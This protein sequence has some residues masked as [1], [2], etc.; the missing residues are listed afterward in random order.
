M[1]DTALINQVIQLCHRAGEA[2]LDVYNHSA[3]FDIDTKADDSP[4]TEADLA[5][6]RI[7]ESGLSEL[8]AGVPVLSEESSLPPFAERS[9][10]Q[11]YWIVDPLDGTKEFINRNGEFTVNVALIEAGRPVLGVVYVPTTGVTYGGADGPGAFKEVD[12]NRQAIAVRSIEA[13]RS[14]GLPV[15]VVA[16]RRHGAS[17]VDQLLDKIAAAFGPV[18]TTSMGSSLKLCLVAEGAADIYPRLAL[19][20]EWDTAAAQAVVECAGGLVVDT[21]FAI[22]RYNTKKDILNPFFYV[23]GDKD[24]DWRGIL[25]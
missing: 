23:F 5:A 9:R 11:R 25:S 22:L 10:W 14:A 6:H 3:G 15:S 2:I 7:L 12:G 19:T 24:V 17:A 21:D 8:L 16:S 4:V 13:R 20:S 1:T 18:E